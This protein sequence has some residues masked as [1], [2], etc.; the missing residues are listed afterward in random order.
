M[1]FRMRSLR[2]AVG[3]VALAAAVAC[4]QPRDDGDQVTG[5]SMAEQH[6]GDDTR[7]EIAVP[8]AVR[9]SVR[10]EM[11]QMLGALDRALGSA[12]ADDADGVAE[13][14][15][16]GGTAI[17]V[18]MDPALADALPAEFVQLGMATHQAFDAV[19]EAAETDL[20]ADSVL[21]ALHQVTNH[22]VACHTSYR[23]SVRNEP[24]SPAADEA[25]S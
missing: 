20:G 8:V 24:S 13:A 19:A 3:L 22:C 4:D 1:R 17:A 10:A 18:D 11:R 12:A 21:A 5:Q 25:G 7:E 16:S 9:Q 14:A 23:L 15:R 6:A 2:T